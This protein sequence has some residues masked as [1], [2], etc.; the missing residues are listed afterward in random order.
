MNEVGWMK[1][2]DTRGVPVALKPCGV[3]SDGLFGMSGRA[4]HSDSSR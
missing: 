2:T 1:K 3:H 4:I